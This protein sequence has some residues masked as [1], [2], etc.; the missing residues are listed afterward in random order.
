MA[1]FNRK[2]ENVPANEAR[3]WPKGGDESTHK[4]SDGDGS[5]LAQRP[6]YNNEELFMI[7]K[8]RAIELL[9]SLG[10]D[11]SLR[12]A[13]IEL[14]AII[15]P[16][17]DLVNFVANNQHLTD[18][19]CRRIFT[20]SLDRIAITFT[21]HGEAIQLFTCSVEGDPD[22]EEQDDPEW[23]WEM[24]NPGEGFPCMNL[25][26]DGCSWHVSNGKPKRCNA[27]PVYESDLTLITT[28]KYKFNPQGARTGSCNR[29]G[30]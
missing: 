21:T 28:C 8:N 25:S 10:L 6:F 26:Q 23:G 15:F 5:T 1:N 16:G 19:C 7:V 18:K 30:A 4:F 24:N 17:H 22:L 3:N 27:F 14:L 20:L 12:Q 2:K 9:P 13:R 11:E 29:C